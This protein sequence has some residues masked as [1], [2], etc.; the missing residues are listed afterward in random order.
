MPTITF[1]NNK[2]GVAKTTSTIMTG[3]A[4]CKR[5][6]KVE[7]RDLDPSGDAT[8]WAQTA[9]RAGTPLPFEVTPANMRNVDAQ[10]DPDTWVLIDTPPEQM[11]IV[12][13]GIDAADL[14]ILVTSPSRHDT[15]HLIEM[16]ECIDRPLTVLVT[17]ARPGTIALK[18]AVD[19]LKAAD[20][21]GFSTI[22]PNRQATL[23]ASGTNILP[24]MSGYQEAATELVE[25]F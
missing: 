14:V 3:L 13:A 1:A 22:I 24:A 17:L 11:Q 19:K 4:L 2:G 20:L 12:Q 21:M 7:V 8:E 23:R 6:L 15:D 25:A 18:N 5:G 16:A 9:S 10:S